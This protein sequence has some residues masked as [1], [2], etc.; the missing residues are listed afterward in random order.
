M[1]LESRLDEKGY[2]VI[3]IDDL[4]DMIGYIDFDGYNADTINIMGVDVI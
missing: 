3:I 1:K 2:Y 4:G